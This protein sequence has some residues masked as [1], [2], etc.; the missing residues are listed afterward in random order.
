[1]QPIQQVA[2]FLFLLGAE[3]GQKILSL[4]DTSEIK[5]LLP[6]IKRLTSVSPA[7]QQAIWAEFKALGYQEAMR[8]T[9]ILTLIRFLFNGSK[10]S[11]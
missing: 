1:M 11:R 10:I 2:V 6:E 3:R 7:D 9:D 8:A 4:M 5:V